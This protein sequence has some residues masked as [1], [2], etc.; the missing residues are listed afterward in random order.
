MVDKVGIAPPLTSRRQTWML[1]KVA[2]TPL[3][4]QGCLRLPPTRILGIG[5][6]MALFVIAVLIISG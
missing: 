2:R 6:W 5:G 1:K 3:V 4:R